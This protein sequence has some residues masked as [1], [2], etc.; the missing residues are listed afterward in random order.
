MDP[1]KSNLSQQFSQPI[2]IIWSKT[3]FG[4]KKLWGKRNFRG[5]RIIVQKKYLGRKIVEI[6]FKKTKKQFGFKFQRSENF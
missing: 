1:G 3:F 4:Q 6:L 5:K 2:N